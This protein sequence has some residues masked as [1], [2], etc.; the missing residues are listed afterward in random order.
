MPISAI[1]EN[2]AIDAKRKELSGKSFGRKVKGGNTNK[3]ARITKQQKT[4]QI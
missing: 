4:S 2:S 3:K 1:M